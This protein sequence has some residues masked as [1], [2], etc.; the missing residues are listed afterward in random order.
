MRRLWKSC[1]QGGSREDY[2]EVKRNA[3]RAVYDAKRAAQL[4]RFGNTSRSEGEVFKIAKQTKTTH[5]DTA[6]DKC[7]RN[8]RGDLAT[9]AHGKHLA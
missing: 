2:L 7:I 5:Q 1:K 3:R 6:G 8:N 9:S 4:E